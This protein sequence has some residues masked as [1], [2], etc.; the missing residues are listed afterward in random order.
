MRV[1]VLPGVYPPGTDTALLGDAMRAHQPPP[2]AD[3]VELCAGTGAIAVE[4]AA[5]GGS[6]VVA[7][8]V[9]PRAVANA[10]LNARLNG[11]G[12]DVRRGDLFA[13]VK[14]RSFDVILVNP[15]YL[16]TPHH[17]DGGGATAWD[18]GPDGRAVLD[19]LCDEIPERLRPGG[20][21][22]I[23]QSTL[24]NVIRTLACLEARGLEV[25]LAAR[26]RGPLGP[27]TSARAGYLAARGVLDG[28]EEELVV[29]G[30]RQPYS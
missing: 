23:V 18:A 6:D 22:L 7:V 17:E 20:L 1:V 8:D 10:R 27:I 29:L 24:A 21:A 11:V 28:D 12:L 19:R 3:V 13:P 25:T 16:P 9:S 30:A 4:A 14:G 26:H 5:R 2:G 15:P